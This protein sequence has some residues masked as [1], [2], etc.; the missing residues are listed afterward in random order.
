MKL[1]VNILTWNTARTLVETLQILKNDLKDIEHEIIIVDNG[2]NDGCQDMATIKNKE[3]LGISKG[4]NQGIGVSNGDYILL[5]DGDIVPVVNSINCLVDW[6]DSNTACEAIGFF[7]NKFTQERNRNGQKNHE[8]YC[9]KLDPVEEHQGHCVYFGM[10]K[11]SVFDKGVMFDEQYGVGYGY[12]DLDFYM[13]MKQRGIK[14]WTAGINHKC[15]KYFHAINSSIKQMGYEKYM[16]SS[17]QR[18]KIF[19]QKWTDVNVIG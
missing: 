1:S 10:Y 5:L 4:K 7:P 2:S 15:G 18:S 9:H 13:Q 14:Q 11:R 3:N 19:K 12:E 8:E 16:S 6:L 17:L